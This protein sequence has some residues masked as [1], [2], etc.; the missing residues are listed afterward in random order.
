MPGPLVAPPEGWVALSIKQPWAALIVA[1]LKSI[2][3][4]TWPTTRRGPVLIHA[5]KIPDERQEGWSL[6]TTPEVKALAELRGGIIGLARL[7]DCRSYDN[8]KS[9]AADQALHRN[10][11]AWF[12]NAGLFGHVFEDVRS[13]DF[14]TY[15]GQTMYF[16]VKDPLSN[17]LRFSVVRE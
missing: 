14:M 10:D 17:R 7:A 1:G 6:V 9:F 16:E 13:L 11:P 8:R 4:R 12:R 3:V 15:K 5:S 2:E